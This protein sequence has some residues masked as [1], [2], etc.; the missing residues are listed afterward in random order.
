[1]SIGPLDTGSIIERLRLQVP[2][3]K[4]VGGAANQAEAMAGSP[5]MPCAF[6]VRAVEDIKTANMTGQQFCEVTAQIHVIYGVRHYQGGQRGQSH[7]EAGDPFVQAGRIALSG[8]R[9]TAPSNTK[10][11]LLLSNGR[12]LLLSNVDAEWWWLD[13]FTVTYRGRT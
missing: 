12:G 6:V 11:E 4:L 10:I 7:A 13:P 5:V 3:L 8:W 9:P 1:M 2:T